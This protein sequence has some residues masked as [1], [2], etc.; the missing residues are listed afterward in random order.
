MQTQTMSS[1]KFGVR[2][3]ATVGMLSAIIIVL[4]VTGLGFI[5]IPPV[6]ATIM[7]LPV[8]IGAIIEGPVVGA[9]TGLFFGLFSMFQAATNPTPTSFLFL[10]PIIAVLPRILIGITSY[11][12]YKLIPGKLNSIKYA[13]AAAVGTLT[14]TILVLGLI[15]LIYLERFAK[16]LGVDIAKARATIVGI[17]IT[18]GIPEVL[19]SIAIVVPVV[20]GV[21]KIRK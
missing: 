3:I 9:I 7:H 19:V 18:N 14:N 15:Y 13:F 10:N 6:K 5:P 1:Q 12:A 2:Q 17:G 11:Y 8:I 4:G 16:V 20:I 21:N